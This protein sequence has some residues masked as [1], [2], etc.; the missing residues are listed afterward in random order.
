MFWYW[1]TYCTRRF[2]PPHITFISPDKLFGPH[3]CQRTT[4]SIGPYRAMPLLLMMQ[5]IPQLASETLKT[6]CCE[7]PAGRQCCPTFL[8]EGPLALLDDDSGLYFCEIRNGRDGDI[9]HL[10]GVDS[11]ENVAELIA[12]E[13]RGQRQRDNDGTTNAPGF[14]RNCTKI[15]IIGRV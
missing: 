3:L 8:V 15:T 1:V 10:N 9:R 7:P 11:S 4:L 6:S 12:T 2:C 14:C 5:N 13:H